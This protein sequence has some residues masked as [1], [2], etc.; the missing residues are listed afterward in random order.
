MP[1]EEK[2]LRVEIPEK[3]IRDAVKKGYDHN[4]DEQVEMATDV[5]RIE[6]QNTI[7]EFIMAT[8]QKDKRKEVM[9]QIEFKG[10]RLGGDGDE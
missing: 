10:F 4:I 8:R 5:L 2:V 9:E 3:L 7:M 1:E 6:L